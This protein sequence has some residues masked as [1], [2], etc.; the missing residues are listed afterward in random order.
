MRGQQIFS[1]ENS[2]FKRLGSDTQNA[3]QGSPVGEHELSGKGMEAPD[4]E[5]PLF[6]PVVNPLK[7][8]QPCQAGTM[9]SIAQLNPVESQMASKAHMDQLAVQA[10]AGQAEAMGQDP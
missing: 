8:L 3:L 7:S 4:N 10:G 2:A 6:T 9:S 1:V 5:L